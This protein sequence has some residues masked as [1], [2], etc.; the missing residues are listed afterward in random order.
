[1]Y[2]RVN[3]IS[4]FCF[5]LFSHCLPTIPRSCMPPGFF[6]SRNRRKYHLLYMKGFSPPTFLSRKTAMMASSYAGKK[7]LWWTRRS[8]LE[9]SSFKMILARRIVLKDSCPHEYRSL[10]SLRGG[11]SR[12]QEHRSLPS[13]LLEVSSSISNQSV[14]L[15]IQNR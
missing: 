8:F 4:V 3:S 1:M 14:F 7:L 10:L 6:I 11:S 9:G 13:L 12:P 2:S 5:R 15:L